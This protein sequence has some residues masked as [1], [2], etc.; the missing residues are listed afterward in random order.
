MGNSYTCNTAFKTLI[1]ICM[2]RLFLIGNGFDLAHGMKTSYSD[3][4]ISY[5]KNCFNKAIE[6]GAFEDDLISIK[7]HPSVFK[8]IET[9]KDVFDLL[10]RV[11]ID[12]LDASTLMRDDYISGWFQTY[13]CSIL[14]AFKHE[15]SKTIFSSI[16]NRKWVDVEIEYFKS[17]IRQPSSHDLGIIKLN[18]GFGALKNKLI[19]YL[20]GIKV[21]QVNNQLLNVMSSGFD[22]FA[23]KAS[24]YTSKKYS[25]PGRLF[26]LNFNYTDLLNRYSDEMRKSGWNFESVQIHGN[27][28]NSVNPIIFGYGDEMSEE[29]KKIELHE[30]KEWLKFFKSFGYGLKS[31][32]HRMLDFIEADQFE[33]FVLGHSCGLSDRVMLNTLFEHP[34]CKLIRVY[35]HQRAAGTTDFM[36]IYQNIARQFSLN[37]RSDFRKKVLSFEV[38]KDLPQSIS[39]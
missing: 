10:K 30:S 31:N 26:L 19:E 16:S 22:E 38:S 11:P 6:D 28:S 37:R 7:R 8:E 20:S 15:F 4:A 14:F 34:N 32:Y 3:F 23:E 9:E 36:D 39:L 12:K 5:L 2:N 33:I 21:P 17:L 27:L 25:P 1:N 35:Y 24:N 18:E 29:Y 13:P